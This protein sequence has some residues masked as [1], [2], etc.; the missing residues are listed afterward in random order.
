MEPKLI[1]IIETF[2][3]DS[4]IDAELLVVLVEKAISDSL[5]E[6]HNN[7]SKYHVDFLNGIYYEITDVGTTQNKLVVGRKSIL[8]HFRKFMIKYLR[9]AS[10]ER[11]NKKN[12]DE[13]TLESEFFIT[14]DNDDYSGSD[15]D[16][17]CTSCQQAP[18]MCS[19]PEQTSSYRF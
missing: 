5:Q 18:C 3:K 2:S 11:L 8:P 6:F 10:A 14:E 1:D 19:D 9:L 17:Y 12:I 4:K 7:G 15:S 16:R 13:D